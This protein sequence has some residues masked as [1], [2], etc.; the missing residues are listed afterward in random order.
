MNE[1]KGK[2]MDRNDE[3]H[4]YECEGCLRCRPAEAL[5]E[6]RK[7][8]KYGDLLKWTTDAFDEAFGTK[9]GK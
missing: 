2:Q 9:G 6:H 7:A 5:P 1:T 4:D 3:T 8:L